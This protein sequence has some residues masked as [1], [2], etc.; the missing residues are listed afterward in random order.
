MNPKVA[1][2]EDT[3]GPPM[4]GSS[5]HCDKASRLQPRW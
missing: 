1:K 4:T 3:A 5:F 2:V